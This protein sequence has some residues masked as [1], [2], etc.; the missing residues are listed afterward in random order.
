MALYNKEILCSLSL[1][2][3]GT[4]KPDFS[5]FTNSDKPVVLPAI[6]GSFIIIISNATNP[7][8]SCKDGETPISPIDNNS[9]K[10]DLFTNPVHVTLFQIGLSNANI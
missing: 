1:F 4:N 7:N 3:I 2:V 9:Y 5:F 10:T 6:K 8:S